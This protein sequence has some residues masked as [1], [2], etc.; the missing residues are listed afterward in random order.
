MMA[1]AAD[2][3][4]NVAP[5]ERPLVAA[6]VRLGLVASCSEIVGSS[7][8]TVSLPTAR[9]SSLLHGCAGL[10]AR[11]CSVVGSQACRLEGLRTWLLAS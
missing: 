1:W 6:R 7:S 5:A 9:C 10:P 2:F 4:Q 11:L 8:A 3:G